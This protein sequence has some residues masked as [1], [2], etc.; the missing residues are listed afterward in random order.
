MNYKNLLFILFLFITNC[1]AYNEIKIT[2]K[3]DSIIF[4][5][6]FINKGFALVYSENFIKI[7][8]YLVKLTIE[9]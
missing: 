7:K 2:K 9:I 1:T 8:L 5:E 4:E 3:T 6:S